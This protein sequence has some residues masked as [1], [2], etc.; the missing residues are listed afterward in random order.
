MS[1]CTASEIGTLLHAYELNQLSEKDVELFEVHLLECD[2][3]FGEADRFSGVSSLI[4]AN[5]DVRKS[6]IEST[7]EIP[8]GKSFLSRALS[9]LWPDTALVFKPAIAYIAIALL[10]YPAYL[11]LRGTDR[12]QIRQLQ[13]LNLIPERS[14]AVATAAADSDILLTFVFYGAEP[15]KDYRLRIESDDNVIIFQQNDFRGFDNYETGRLL[16]PANKMIPGGYSLIIEDPEGEPPFNKM[17]YSFS[18]EN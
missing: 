16:L 7:Y 3:C 12:G 13:I 2:Y 10:A 1:R 5:K 8:A 11:G 18:I 14:A 17:E 6:I 4:V 15:G 9:H